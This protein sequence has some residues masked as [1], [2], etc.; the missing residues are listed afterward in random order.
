MLPGLGLVYKSRDKCVFRVNHVCTSVLFLAKS[1][2]RGCQQ[3]QY[4]REVTSR[5]LKKIT[6]L[7]KESKVGVCVWLLNFLFI[8]YFLP[9]STGQFHVKFSSL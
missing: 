3:F 8:F 2:L 5:F 9:H 4:D 7:T 1:D 6:S